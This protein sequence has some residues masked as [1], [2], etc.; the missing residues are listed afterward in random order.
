MIPRK[1]QFIKTLIK[2]VFIVCLILPDFGL[3][4]C[5]RE[6]L[7]RILRLSITKEVFIRLRQEIAVLGDHILYC[8]GIISMRYLK[9]WTTDY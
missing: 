7:M 5:W 1:F 9:E 2:K 6:K 8:L 4:I 3:M